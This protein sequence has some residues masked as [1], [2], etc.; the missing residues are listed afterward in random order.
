ME[1][2]VVSKADM[3]IRPQELSHRVLQMPPDDATARQAAV[4]LRKWLGR[5]RPALAGALDIRAMG[6]L[7]RVSARGHAPEA[8]LFELD[9][10]LGLHR[11]LTPVGE[12][13]VPIQQ[14]AIG[15]SPHPDLVPIERELLRSRVRYFP[16]PECEWFDISTGMLTLTDRRITYEPEHIPIVERDEPKSR[17]LQVAIEQ[18]RECRRGHWWDI[19][20]LMVVTR[21]VA[22]RFGWPAERRDAATVFEVAEWLECLRALTEKTP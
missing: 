13:E 2:V 4:A 18:V 22:Y 19:P 1:I 10:L 14:F 7:V 9:D 8:M 6:G 17:V 5:K 11:D 16:Y 20:C 12:I 15:A 21:P 3:T